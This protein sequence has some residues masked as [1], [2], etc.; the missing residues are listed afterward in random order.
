MGETSHRETQQTPQTPASPWLSLALR[1]VLVLWVLQLAWLAWHLRQESADLGRRLWGQTWGEAIRRDDPF[2]RW[3][4][5]IQRLIP[6]DA[7]YLFLDNYEAGKEIEARYHLFPRKHLLR[8]PGA[9]PSLLF[10]TLRQ[11]QVSHLLKRDGKPPPGP[12]LHAALDLGAVE[13]LD[14][15]GP[16][17]VYRLHPERLTGGFYD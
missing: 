14:L 12:G 2:Y 1:L 4:L 16:G 6:P 8:L 5:E 10:Y 15:P 11:H 13:P 9:P 7:V 17:A 3:L